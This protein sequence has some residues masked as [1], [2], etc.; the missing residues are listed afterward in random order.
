MPFR[1]SF[2]IAGYHYSGIVYGNVYNFCI[3]AVHNCPRRHSPS[4]GVPLD[5][6]LEHLKNSLSRDAPFCHPLA[7]MV[8]E[9]YSL[10]Q[11]DP[12]LAALAQ[13]HRYA[14]EDAPGDVVLRHER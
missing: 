3:D 1:I 14:V 6:L 2:I 12:L 4:V 11:I 13:Q 7:G 8:T 5:S 9:Y 10:L